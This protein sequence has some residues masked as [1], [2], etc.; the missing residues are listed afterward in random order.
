MKK[1]LAKKARSYLSGTSRNL[2]D[3]KVE[4]AIE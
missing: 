3:K 2:L 4:S 1:I